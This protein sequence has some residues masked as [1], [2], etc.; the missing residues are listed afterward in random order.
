[1]RSINRVKA[2]VH[3]HGSTYNTS[4]GGRLPLSPSLHTHSPYLK[5]GCSMW[6]YILNIMCGED[7][8][9]IHGNVTK[10][11]VYSLG[12]WWITAIYM[13]IA[14]HTFTLPKTMCFSSPPL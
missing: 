10:R 11:H 1:M 13:I 4:V 8:K 6:E 3:L 9:R 2:K 14:L 7:L 5:L 12:T